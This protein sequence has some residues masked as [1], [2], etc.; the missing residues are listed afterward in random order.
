MIENPFPTR[1]EVSD[2]YNCVRQKSDCTMLSG[3]TT[4]GKYPIQAVEMMTAVIDEA[5]ANMIYE[6]EDFSNDGL[7]CRDIEKKHLIKNALV[8]S[9]S[10]DV[11][12][13]L[14]F[15]KTGRLARFAAAFRPNKDVYAFTM[16]ECSLRYMNALFGIRPI[17]L[18][19]WDENLEENLDNAIALLKEKNL[20]LVG[21]RIVAVN[22]IQKEGREI[23]VMEIITIE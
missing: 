21:D 15:T 20:L 7:C 3:E 17:L 13:V 23:P 14:I 8:T 2:I 6:H 9:E 22:D 11:R 4:I 19:K 12:A 18:S 10:L 16:K 5:E 1:A